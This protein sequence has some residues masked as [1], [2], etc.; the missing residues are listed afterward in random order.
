M[1]VGCKDKNI[2]IIK[3]QKSGQ[4]QL[5][6]QDFINGIPKKENPRFT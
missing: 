3:I 6:G 5:T 1:V 4:R 2:E